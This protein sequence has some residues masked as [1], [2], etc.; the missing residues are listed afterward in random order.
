MDDENNGWIL[1]ENRESTNG[2]TWVYR[3]VG[4]HVSNPDKQ[5]DSI[6]VSLEAETCSQVLVGGV[7]RVAVYL[8]ASMARDLAASLRSVLGEDDAL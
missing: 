8:T 7:M 5:I 4:R 6:R 1:K 3:T 2:G